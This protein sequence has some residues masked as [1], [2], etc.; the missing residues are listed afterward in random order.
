MEPGQLVFDITSGDPNLTGNFGILAQFNFE[1]DER[2]DL[3]TNLTGVLP[4]TNV[5]SETFTI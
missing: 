4:W 5:G 3:T 1:S 2:N